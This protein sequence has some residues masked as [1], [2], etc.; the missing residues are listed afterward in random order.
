MRKIEMSDR[1]G[2]ALLAGTGRSDITP[3]PG[4]WQ[5]GFGLRERPS[6]G[7]HDRLYVTALALACAGERALWLSADI[8]SLTVERAESIRNRIAEETSIPASA[9]MLA[10]THTHA[11][12]ATGVMNRLETDGGWWA[13]FASGCLAAAREAVAGM[14]P[15]R[16]GYGAGCCQIGVN[17]RDYLRRG[18]PPGYCDPEV[19]VLCLFGKEPAPLAVL[20]NYACHPVMLGPENLEISADYPGVVRRVVEEVFPSC[21]CLFLSGAAGDINPRAGVG[22]SYGPME[23]EGRI[24]AGEILRVIRGIPAQDGGPLRSGVF[25]TT[26]PL[27]PL[28]PREDLAG[29]AARAR[30]AYQSAGG[31]GPR[32]MA[33]TAL[34]WAERVLE[35]R[36]RDGAPATLRVSLQWFALGEICTICAW[37]FE[38]FAGVGAEIKRRAGRPLLLAGYA[39]GCLGYLPG[40][41]DYALGGYEVEEACKWY[42]HLTGFAPGAADMVVEETV[43]ILA[44]IAVSVDCGLETPGHG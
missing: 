43:R 19:G 36:E 35:A 18:G 14:V 29:E 9:I 32:R 37:P 17:R 31:V 4:G 28:P 30:L 24:L 10:A 12:P 44:G 34:D 15:A 42:K 16:A 41:D 25:T 6:T 5:D 26:I 13:L 21:R 8:S 23:R 2:G 38:A 27:I 20:A 7:V 3:E 40:R 39:N 22:V 33:G 11:G 1:C